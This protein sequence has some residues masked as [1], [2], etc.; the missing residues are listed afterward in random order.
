MKRRNPCQKQS[1]EAKWEGNEA[2]AKKWEKL[3]N[4]DRQLAQEVAH[5]AI[6]LAAQERFGSDRAS[7]GSPEK[8]TLWGFAR[9]IN[10]RA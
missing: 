4:L 5:S 2:E 6:E 10:S 9:E 1:L 7:T 8:Y 3:A